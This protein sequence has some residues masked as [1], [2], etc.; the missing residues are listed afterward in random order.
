MYQFI[1]ERYDVLKKRLSN[2]IVEP[3]WGWGFRVA[4]AVILPTFLSIYTGNHDFFWMIVAAE[5]VSIVELKGSA[6]LR[7][8]LL[9]AAIAFTV[10]F[11]IIGS[12]VGSFPYLA[13]LLLLPIALATGLM[14]NLGDWGL[15]LALNVYLFY[16]IASNHPT[17]NWSDL[18]ERISYVALGGIWA[19]LVGVFSFSFLPQGKP[20]R[21]TI[22]HIWLAVEQLAALV[23]NNW[24]TKT[25]RSSIR[26]IYLKEKNIRKATDESLALFS[27]LY[28]SK[29][30]QSAIDKKMSYARRCAT[31][32][33]L[34]VISIAEQS[35]R[36]FK[37]ALDPLFKAQLFSLLK[38]VEQIANRMGYYCY[39]MKDEELLLIQ[40]RL[41]RIAQFDVQFLKMP[42]AERKNSKELLMH[43]RR[44]SRLV[45]LSLNTL[46]GNKEKRI[47]RQYS[48]LQT[49]NILHP[50]HLTLNIKQFLN[51][52]NLTLKY[53]LRMSIA[54]SL[55]YL[56]GVMYFP[57]HSYW[58]P[59]TTIIVTQPFFGATLRRGIERSIGTVAGVLLGGLLL[60]LP[61]PEI[62]RYM[63][64]FFGAVLMI[65]N[66]RKNYA[67]AAFFISLFL[68]G[69]M[70]D[71]EQV[72]MALIV[73]RILATIIGAA[74][75][76]LGGFLLFPAWDKKLLPKYLTN[77]VKANYNYFFYLFY[78]QDAQNPWSQFKIAA[79]S[80]NSN[81]YDS[82]NRY[83]NE[84][85][86]R[87]KNQ[88]A[89]YFTAIT[90]NIR[91][92]RELNFYQDDSE[93]ED[94]QK[95]VNNREQQ[96]IIPLLNKI[97]HL[98]Q[99]TISLLDERYQ[100]EKNIDW[101]AEKALKNSIN[102]G[103]HQW[104]CMERLYLELKAL[105][106]GLQH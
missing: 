46:A 41:K 54:A 80:S 13:V 98:F 25:K 72:S 14:K 28:D 18:A 40:T 2:E 86:Y 75:S 16:L 8:R 44:Y 30:K 70:A 52:D 3:A 67:W 11:T 58:L 73:E 56:I 74:I 43:I 105:Y 48:L 4:I 19:M 39:T 76:I 64:I 102:P 103:E 87:E 50:K 42:D 53:A 88:A 69:L 22:A 6:G 96:S 60:A 31:I 78:E 1:E 65:Y 71:N 101:N 63:L 91:I 33:G 23:A 51:F 45:E 55:S 29:Q 100:L 21:R 34:Q 17:H 92:T 84:P 94:T 68:I 57:E 106:S 66:L 10:L 82:L 7:L 95:Q 15:A 35:E 104:Q 12:L 5:T 93:A 38:L 37:E 32:S 20:Y 47:Y 85:K 79:E 9:I 36:L 59:L 97:H 49:L 61:H 27:A 83:L 99:Q 62:M 81:A 90:Y 77:A 89:A 26:A 24:D